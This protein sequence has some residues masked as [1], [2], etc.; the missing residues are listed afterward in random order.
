MGD[1]ELWQATYERQLAAAQAAGDVE[2][3]QRLVMGQWWR[4]VGELDRIDRRW[5]KAGGSVRGKPSALRLQQRAPVRDE[6]R[7]ILTRIVEWP[8]AA[9]GLLD[10]RDLKAWRPFL[11]GRLAANPAL[12]Q[13]MLDRAFAMRRGRAEIADAFIG[14]ARA[15]RDVATL[16]LAGRILQG[17]PAGDRLVFGRLVDAFAALGAFD[18]ASALAVQAVGLG[19]VRSFLQL[20]AARD[21]L[22][23]LDVADTIVHRTLDSGRLPPR[24]DHELAGFLRVVPLTATTIARVL[25]LAGLIVARPLREAVAADVACH[26][27][28]GG[29]VDRARRL[30]ASMVNE[31]QRRRLLGAMGGVS[32]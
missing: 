12:R 16:E 2:A 7:V 6:M 20:L 31:P 25:D 9:V 1:T 15:K 23:A 22:A 26:L 19:D 28:S 13:A 27:V 29:D 32:G 14:L 17:E 18:S 21:P 10:H 8:Q 3:A 24:L 30:L 11:I 5:L 4:I